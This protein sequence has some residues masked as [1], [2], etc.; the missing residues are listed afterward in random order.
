M[1]K[2]FE[3]GD[4]VKIVYYPITAAVGRTAEVLEIFPRVGEQFR[5][6]GFAAIVVQAICPDQTWYLLRDVA[7]DPRVAPHPWLER[8][9]PVPLNVT[10]TAG[11]CA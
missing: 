10:E 4:I 11:N 1:S 2:D 6:R 9:D 8:A 7:G 3:P 5:R